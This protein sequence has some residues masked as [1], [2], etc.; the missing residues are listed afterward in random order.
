[1]RFVLERALFA[2]QSDH[3]ALGVLHL[4]VTAALDRHHT[5]QTDPPYV[6]GA[7]NREIDAWLD[8]R[9]EANVLREFLASSN[10]MAAG[11][12][13]GRSYDQAVP[14]W[15]HLAESFDTFV[16]RRA[17]SDWPNLRLTLP[18][19]LALLREPVHLVLENEWNDF[20]FVAHLAGPTTGPM[21][22][23]LK[24]VSGK[25]HIHGGGGGAAKAFLKNLLEHPVTP[26]KWRRVLR[27]WVLFEQDAGETD[28]RDPSAEAGR[29]RQVCEEVQAAY[30]HRLSWAC[31]RRR[32]IESF[33]PDVGLQAIM[34]AAPHRAAMAQQILQW[35][36]AP[37]YTRHAW[38]FDFKKG[39]KGD[40]RS[41]LDDAT[42]KAAKP[43]DGPVDATML[44][45]PFDALTPPEV[46]A[47]ASGLGERLLNLEFNAAPTWTARIPDEYDRGPFGPSPHPDQAP[48][49]ELIQALI[50]RL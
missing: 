18:D 27:A 22:R 48:R 21:L 20:A 5:I 31:L 17:A 40:L 23:G 39:L 46:T 32:E 41:D 35:R 15:W 14:A 11:V 34:A 30:A 4:L 3:E 33:V 26:S 36:S 49:V 16:E 37:A 29:M 43:P 9:S 25:L 24:D 47:L 6:L 50:D 28:A 44:K 38:A 2:P 10:V 1:M 45:A 8:K 19:A 13:V 12:R 42:R 7:D